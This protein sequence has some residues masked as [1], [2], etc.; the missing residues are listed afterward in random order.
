MIHDNIQIILYVTGTITASML[1]QFVAPARMLKV[2][3]QLEVSDPV[4]L[5]FARAAGLA[6][7]LQGALLIWAAVDPALRIPVVT[8]VAIGKSG[9]IGT[10][11]LQSQVNLEG[12]RVDDGLRHGLR[13]R[14]SGVPSRLLTMAPGYQP[15]G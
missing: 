6:V 13:A 11:L 5:F 15:Q 8:V 2:G 1:L 3:N 14:I 9:F 7:G 4:A 12:L 10:V